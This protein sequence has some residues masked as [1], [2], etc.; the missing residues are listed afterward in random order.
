MILAF[1]IVNSKLDVCSVA[2]VDAE[3]HVGGSL[4]EIRSFSLVEI[5]DLT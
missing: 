5:L 3:E 2:D 4:V 1:E